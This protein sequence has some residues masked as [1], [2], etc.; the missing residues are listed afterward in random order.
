MKS[1]DKTPFKTGLENEQ[2]QDL[3]HYPDG[4]NPSLYD[5]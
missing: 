4:F 5:L 3:E 1:T 2:E